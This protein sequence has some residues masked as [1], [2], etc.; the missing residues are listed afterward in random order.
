M[1]AL[2]RLYIRQVAIGFALAAVFTALLLWFDVAGLRHLVTHTAEGPLAVL[3]LVVFN[4]IVFSGVQFGIAVMR[5]AEPPP[6][7]GSRRRIGP[8]P[9]PV[10][11]R[12]E[13]RR[14]RG[15]FLGQ[16]PGREG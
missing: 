15:S 2:V 1:P 9:L 6:A 3:L 14:R 11:V 13:P 16:G 5:M 4:G 10:A 12:V 8:E 7:G